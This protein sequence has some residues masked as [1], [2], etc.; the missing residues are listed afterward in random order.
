MPP[1][2]CRALRTVQR[3]PH[4][5]RRQSVPCSA[6]GDG[7]PGAGGGTGRA[8]PVPPSSLAGPRRSG[9]ATSARGW[10]RAHPSGPTPSP[11]GYIQRTAALMTANIRHTASWRYKTKAPTYA[12]PRYS[13]PI[14]SYHH[15]RTARIVIGSSDGNCPT[16]EGPRLQCDL[17][18]AELRRIGG[19]M[20]AMS[21][22]FVM[23][24][25]IT[26]WCCC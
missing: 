6:A 9:P 19:V 17:L 25:K 20:R 8:G 3:A 5:S 7:P 15:T 16:G 1:C 14:K 21:I 13:R 2:S 26:L 12:L 10:F 23:K 4:L 11:V 18:P 22:V 24:L